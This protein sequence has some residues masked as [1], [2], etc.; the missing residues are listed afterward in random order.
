M[1]RLA[2][3]SYFGRKAPDGAIFG[4][5]VSFFQATADGNS[6]DY[7]AT[8]DYWLR[9][10]D[11]AEFVCMRVSYGSSSK[12]ESWSLHLQ[13]RAEFGVTSP[14]GAYHFAN[15][16]DVNL[17]AQNFVAELAKYQWDFAMLD[18]EHGG[19]YS[20]WIRDFSRIVQQLSGYTVLLYSNKG[21][22][23]R[24]APDFGAE[25]PYWGSHYPPASSIPFTPTTSWSSNDAPLIP[26]QYADVG[27]VCWQWQSLTPQYGHL[28][29]NISTHPELFRKVIEDMSFDDSD[30]ARLEHVEAQLATVLGVLG[31]T[32][33]QQQFNQVLGAVD[34]LVRRDVPQL[35]QIKQAFA[36]TVKSLPASS[37]GAT[38]TVDSIAEAVAKR[39]F[40]SRL[41]P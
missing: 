23:D 14:V 1:S 12:D 31:V 4:V 16:G 37:N 33:G 24:N 41:A 20:Q 11:W 36:D 5:D 27:F 28:D 17:E 22:M 18:C 39:L 25:L 34:A 2:Y 10:K 19:G 6:Y 15:F 8:R 35:D 26:D 40:G 9:F 29:L 7:P 38:V 13:A 32:E 30:K 21:W 3:E